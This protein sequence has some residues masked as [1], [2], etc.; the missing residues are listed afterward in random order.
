MSGPVQ[1]L[2]V[3][4]EQPSFSGEAVA[5]LARLREQGVVRLIDAL[6]VHRLEDG[7]FGVAGDRRRLALS[8]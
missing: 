6:L 4:F 5:E 3:G 8:G 2:V 1:V 7:R